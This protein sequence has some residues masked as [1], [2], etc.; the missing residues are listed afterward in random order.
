MAKFDNVQL[1]NTVYHLIAGKGTVTE[2]HR[3]GSVKR[4]FNVKFETGKASFDFDGY[5]INEKFEREEKIVTL[6]WNEVKLP[7]EEEDKKPFDLVEFLREN[8]KPKEFEYEEKNYKFMFISQDHWEAGYDKYYEEMT[9]YFEEISYK[10]A[11]ILNEQ[12]I[13]P[14]QLK[15]AYKELGWL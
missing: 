11:T 6:Y 10:T 2:I 1:N 15:Q 14:Q 13:T 8:V 3:F 5:L 7:T 9:V 12:D 4:F